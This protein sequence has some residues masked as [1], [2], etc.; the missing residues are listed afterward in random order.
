MNLRWGIEIILYEAT[1]YNSVESQGR[2]RFG[3]AS[4]QT[5]GR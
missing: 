3:V 5:S 4:A 2:F 1:E